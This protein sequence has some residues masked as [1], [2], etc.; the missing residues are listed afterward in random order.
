M[1]ASLDASDRQ[2]LQRRG[3]SNTSIGLLAAIPQV[4][5]VIG[6]I[7][8]GRRSIVRRS[9]AGTLILPMLLRCTSRV[10]DDGL[11][12]ATRRAV[13]GR[14]LRLDRRLTAMS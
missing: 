5:T 8:W 6:M 7:W 14:L 11:V 3:Q 10:A 9:G 4:C 13:A 12:L 1:V 2:E